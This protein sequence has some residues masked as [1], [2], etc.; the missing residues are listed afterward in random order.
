[1]RPASDWGTPSMTS[2]GVLLPIVFTPRIDMLT[3]ELV[4][5]KFL[6]WMMRLAAAPCSACCTLA[7]GRFSSASALTVD[8]DEMMWRRCIWP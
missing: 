6:V 3:D 2:S 8:T 1:M 4:G 5:S 7:T